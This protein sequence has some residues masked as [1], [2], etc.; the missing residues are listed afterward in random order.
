MKLLAGGGHR[1]LE[2]LRDHKF[3]LCFLAVIHGLSIIAT[4]FRAP[5]LLHILT[6]IFG[7]QLLVVWFYYLFSYVCLCVA[8]H[9]PEGGEGQA[10]A[11]DLSAPVAAQ[12]QSPSR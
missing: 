10:P 11:R 9:F 12:S 1:P 8:D 7:L 4:G 3:P 6:S 5:F 2:E